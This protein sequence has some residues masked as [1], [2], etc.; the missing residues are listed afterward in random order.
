MQQISGEQSQD[1]ASPPPLVIESEWV[2]W[3]A[4]RPV[5]LYGSGHFAWLCKI[6][7]RS[8]R[9]H[10]F[11]LHEYSNTPSEYPMAS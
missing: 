6:Y 7:R 2:A 9:R 1:A 11:S 8:V 4:W 3:F 10:G 5:R